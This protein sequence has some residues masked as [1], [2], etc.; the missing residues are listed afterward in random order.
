MNKIILK[1][2]IVV[3]IIII[4]LGIFAEK[5]VKDEVKDSGMPTQNIYIDGMYSVP[6][7]STYTAKG[8]RYYHFSRLNKLPTVSIYDKLYTAK[9]KPRWDAMLQTV[10]PQNLKYVIKNTIHY[11]Q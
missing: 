1:I 9:G 4:F 3:S 11:K 7:V 8:N 5:S 10:T 6:N 2:L